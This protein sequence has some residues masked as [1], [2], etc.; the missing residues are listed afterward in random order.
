MRLT[1]H[2]RSSAPASDTRHPTADTP[3]SPYREQAEALREYVVAAR[4]RLHENPELSFKEEQTAR[5]VADELQA[6]G[7]EPEEGV[8][9]Y[10][11]RAVLRGGRPGRTIG[12]RADMDALP[13]TEENDLPFRSRNAGAMHACGHDAHTA[14]LLGAAKGLRPKQAELSGNVVFLFQPAEELPPGGAKAMIAA[15]AMQNPTVD[16]VFGLHQGTAIVA[17]KMAIASGPRSASSD[18][19]RITIIGRGGHAAMPHQAVDPIAVTGVL[20]TALQQLVS[21]QLPPT[22]PA[23]V[24]IGMIHGGTKENIIP[25]E[26][27]LA[28]TVRALDAR[29]REEI[30]RRME[31]MVKGISEGYGARYNLEYHFGYPVLVN[32]ASMAELARRAATRVVG[33]ENVLSNGPGMAAEDFAY[34][35]QEAPGAFGSVGV[36]TP[37]TSERPSSHS[38]RFMLDEAGLPIGVAYYLSLVDLYLSDH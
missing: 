30:P 2:E 31:A 16:A 23:V 6:M 32:D 17:G 34:F 27:T 26:V 18:S 3:Q 8:G 20:I 22:Q 13:I 9:G 36:G 37:G 25:D 5:F 38:P 4:R 10:G 1:T 7:Y 33:E 19:F 24:T 28:G 21:R 14:M 35:L 15:G 11:V 12:L 29:V